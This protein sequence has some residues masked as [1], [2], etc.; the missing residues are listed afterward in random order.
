MLTINRIWMRL[1]LLGALIMAITLVYGLVTKD[2]S[3]LR[4]GIVIWA[5]TYVLRI[6]NNKCRKCGQS[7][8]KRTWKQAGPDHQICPRCGTRHQ[9][10]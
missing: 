2:T 7:Y 9:I 10:L 6:M 3:P 1:N 4:I 5:L 8:N